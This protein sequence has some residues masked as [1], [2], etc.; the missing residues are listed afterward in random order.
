MRCDPLK[1]CNWEDVPRRPPRR[2]CPEL[3]PARLLLMARLT[4]DENLE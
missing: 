3:L 4:L 2:A 1:I